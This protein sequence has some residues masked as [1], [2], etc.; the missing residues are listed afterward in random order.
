[1]LGRSKLATKHGASVEA[2]PL[3]DL[4]AGQLVGGG[5]Q[6]DPRHVREFL[7]DRRQPDIFRA[8][9]VAPLRHAMRLV[10]REQ[11]Q[12]RP[13]QQRQAA[14]RQQPL[15][16]DI[17]QV[18]F[19]V[20]QLLL[21]RIGLGIGQRRIQHRGA[22]A[23]FAAAPRPGRASARS[24]ATP[25]CR[26]LRATA[27]AI[28]STATCRRRSASAPGNRRHS[29]TWRDDLLLMA[30]KAGQAEHG[31]QQ[32]D[33]A[34]ASRSSRFRGRRTGMRAVGRRQRACDA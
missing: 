13:R 2:E 7:G 23:G 31:I 12:F 24:A 4:A 6:R 15:R 9:V 17:E 11:R 22:D 28:G 26:S 34:R 5:G 3:G 21:D 18:E 32:R 10:D 25:R 20:E 30:A 27:T 1:M 19:A 33:S 29:A 16:R 8:E 14:R